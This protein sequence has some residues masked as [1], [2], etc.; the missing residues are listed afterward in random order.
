MRILRT[1][2]HRQRRSRGLAGTLPY[3]RQQ[4]TYR[5]PV[6]MG[7]SIG[8]LGYDRENPEGRGSGR[9][10]GLTSIGTT[11]NCRTG[12]LGTANAAGY[13]LGA[14]ISAP[15][16]KRFGLHQAFLFGVVATVFGIAA[17]GISANYYWLNAWRIVAGVTGA[18]CFVLGNAVA[19]GLA[20]GLSDPSARAGVISLF[21][22]SPGAGII[23]SALS[24]PI[25]LAI[26][27]QG[28]WKITWFVLG[29][30]SA[31]LACMTWLGL[32]GIKFGQALP[33]RWRGSIFY[34]STHTAAA[35]YC[36]FG[37][38]YICYLTFMYAHLRELGAGESALVSFWCTIG[39]ATMISVWLWAR[40]M[41]RLRRAYAF[42]LLSVIVTVGA[43]IP[44]ISDQIELAFVSAAIFGCALFS[45]P[46][47]TT[48]FV[49]RN[50]TADQ[51]PRALGILTI[52]FGIGQIIGPTFAGFASDV[53]GTLSY[54]LA[55][56]CVFLLA[57]A[58]AAL[59]QRDPTPAQ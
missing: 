12:W 11:Q 21:Y 57:G 14:I 53:G 1:D 31:V 27:G 19:A 28:S 46:A 39:V 38:G 51:W 10:C 41:E 50:F 7:L 59:F 26:A 23:L 24:V 54:G 35:G 48:V 55:W 17:M 16:A 30:I 52:S 49:R 45:V 34:R 56:G 18:F 8:R 44:L 58:A 33:T 15:V 22:A 6:S 37:A 40:L 5:Q 9:T 42:S 32:R 20:A 47:S 43:S 13:L 36:A 25:V 2:C 3:G 29:G 4:I